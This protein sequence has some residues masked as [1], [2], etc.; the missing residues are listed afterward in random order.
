MNYTMVV[1]LSCIARWQLAEC[2]PQ[3]AMIREII[4]MPILS[5]RQELYRIFV[6]F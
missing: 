3:T 4:L 2:G 5:H 1:L 6:M